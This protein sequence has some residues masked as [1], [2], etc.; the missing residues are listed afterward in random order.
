MQLSFLAG[1]FNSLYQGNTILYSLKVWGAILYMHETELMSF[2]DVSECSAVSKSGYPQSCI[3]M[4][5]FQNHII[6]SHYLLSPDTHFIHFIFLEPWDPG[7]GV[8]FN[9]AASIM[10]QSLYVSVA[11]R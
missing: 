3:Y 10:H 9:V 1:L 11:H 6:F 5:A 2:S 7:W 8:L 4:T